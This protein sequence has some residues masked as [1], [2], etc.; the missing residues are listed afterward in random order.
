MFPASITLFLPKS[1]SIANELKNTAM[2]KFLLLLFAFP[3]AALAICRAGT[4]LTGYSMEKTTVNALHQFTA[5]AQVIDYLNE[6]DTLAFSDYTHAILLEQDKATKISLGNATENGMREIGFTFPLNEE[7]FTHF[8]LS[9]NGSVYFGSTNI[10]PGLLAETSSGRNLLYNSLILPSEKMWSI[11]LGKWVPATVLATDATKIQYETVDDVLYIG[12]EGLSVLDANGDA[13]LTAAF[14]Y[15][16]EKNGNV[17]LIVGNLT[18]EV[19]DSYYFRFGLSSVHGT[20]TTTQYLYSWDG[21]INRFN[22]PRLE[23]STAS[24][25]LKLAKFTY[26]TPPPCEAVTDLTIDLAGSLTS[27]VNSIGVDYSFRWETAKASTLMMVLSESNA[28]LKSYLKD[29]TTYTNA[30]Q[31]NDCPVR[32]G[33]SYFSDFTGLK[34]YTQYYV[35]VFPYNTACSDGPVYGQEIIVPATTALGP[36][37]N[38]SVS[39]VD[40]EKV[41]LAIDLG[42]ASKYVLAVAEKSLNTNMNAATANLLQN[43]TAYTVGQELTHNGI[44]FSILAVGATSTTFEADNLQAG[45]DYYFYVWAMDGESVYSKTYVEALDR[46]I[47]DAPVVLGFTDVIASAQPAGWSSSTWKNEDYNLEGQHFVVNNALF[48]FPVYGCQTFNVDGTSSEPASAYVVSPWMEGAGKNFSAVFNVALYTVSGMWEQ[49]VSF[50]R[51]LKASDSVIFQMQ[52]QGDG[53]Q[54]RTI[55]RL[56]NQT[57]WAG[58]GFGEIVSGDFSPE[59]V[60]RFRVVFY[61]DYAT[62]VSMSG[63][64]FAIESLNVEESLPCK[65]PVSIVV[66][67]ESI[68]Y[69]SVRIEWTDNNTP[70]AESFDIRYKKETEGDDEWST[71]SATGQNVVL[72]NLE[73]SSTYHVEI[74]AVC[75]ADSKSIVKTTSFTTALAIPYSR[76]EWTDDLSEMGYS[77]LVGKPGETLQSDENSNG[78]FIKDE[79]TEPGTYN[80]VNRVSLSLGYAADAWLL[81]PMLFSAKS[82][83]AKLTLSLS[84]YEIGFDEDWNSVHNDAQGFDEKDSLFV[85]RSE[86]GTFSQKDRIGAVALA[87]LTVEY[88]DIDL[89]FEVTEG[90]KNVIGFY[91]SGVAQADDAFDSYVMIKSI[92]IDYSAFFYPAVTNLRTSNLGKTSVTIL[93]DGAAESYALLYKKRTDAEYDT[94]YTEETQYKLEDLTPGTQYAYRVFGYYGEDRTLPGI[95]SAERYVNTVK[96]CV[97]PTDF[98]VVGT[99]W[100]SVTLTCK[101]EDSRQ[102]SI[103][104]QDME[105]YPEAN[106]LVDWSNEELDV[107]QVKGLFEFG[108][109]FPYRAAVRALCPGDTS[110][111]TETIDFVT[112]PLPECGMPTDLLSEYNATARTA[113]LSWKSGVN[114]EST[115]IYS[116]MES[117]ILWDTAET[118]GNSYVLQN[119]ENNK[120]YYWRLQAICDTWLSSEVTEQKKVGN[121]SVLPYAKSLSVRVTGK[122]IVVLNPERRYIKQLNV[123]SVTGVLLRSYAVNADENVYIHTD[124]GQGMIVVEAVGSATEKAAVKAVVM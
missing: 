43:G 93:W 3:M 66:P 40:R 51:S 76:N 105:S 57:P 106:Y 84:A 110:A 28:S 86:N 97:P 117:E 27:D 63:P 99:T 26:Q 61:Q 62:A 72:E 79:E 78:W 31:I 77:V 25:V 6:G 39:S 55:A 37:E 116:R 113:T 5:N 42:S 12:Y 107:L 38:I 89:E 98:A 4:P 59:K 74:N 32:V 20:T 90:A 35:H 60:F 18:P 96:E 34:P 64:S 70:W 81:S 119:V 94:V 22:T 41:E 45:Q 54:W 24:D 122:E 7:E 48:D 115:F 17:S 95:V 19:N 123:Y 65:Y 88:Q 101:S 85:F 47:G 36:V 69:S 80:Y 67:E 21:I 2:K 92:D 50:Y 52:E 49:T 1:I 30:S 118:F 87:D 29:G 23:L 71:V 108:L 13:H 83:M 82:G 114:N 44:K 11:S 121:E 16:I 14:Q 102:I 8:G 100:Q 104:A 75:S 53:E 68:S 73:S 103:T 58:N 91:L 111:W 120:V 109:E 9:G 124:L 112:A 46:T 33:T 56:D 15:E 10:T